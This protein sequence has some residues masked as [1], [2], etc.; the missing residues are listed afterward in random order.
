[1]VYV[2]SPQ[3]EIH[4]ILGIALTLMLVLSLGMVFT[5]APA[6]ADPDEWSTYDLPEE[7]ADGDYFYDSTI[8][9]GPGPI[10]RGIDGTFWVY[11]E[12]DG[13]DELLRSIDTEGRGWEATEYSADVGGGA[14]VAIAPSSI[15]ADVV[16]VADATKVYKTEDGGDSFATVVESGLDLADGEEISCLSV[17]YLAD[18]SPFVFIGTTGS[19]GHV[20]YLDE[21]AFGA[22]WIDLELGGYAVYGL[23]V[24]PDFDHDTLVAALAGLN[25]A[26]GGGGTGTA[27]GWSTIR[28][29]SGT[30]SALLDLV[31][32]H[33]YVDFIPDRG[34]TLGDLDSLTNAWGFW[35]YQEAS[36]GWG[37]QLELKFAPDPADFGTDFIDITVMAAQ[38]LDLVEGSWTGVTLADDL[39]S[40]VWWGG[41]VAE[42][43]EFHEGGKTLQEAIDA[44]LL[45]GV[46][47]ASW[48]LARVRV[49]LWEPSPPRKCY[50]DDITIDGTTYD[51]EQDVGLGFVATNDGSVGVWDYLPLEDVITN[52]SDPAFVEDFDIDDAFEFFVGVCAYD[53]TGGV[54]RVYDETNVEKVGDVDKAIISLDLAGN[55]GD[56]YL[57]AGAQG[58]ADVWYSDDDGVSWL[59]ASDEG[60]Q[61]SGATNTY[62]IADADIANNGIGWAATGVA[63]GAVSMT[64]DGGAV[65]LG[66]SLIDTTIDSIEGLAMS[67]DFASPGLMFV[68]TDSGTTDSVFRYDGT[69]WERVYESTQYNQAIDLIAVSPDINTD[70][71]VFLGDTVSNAIQSTRATL[72]PG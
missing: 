36:E 12:F 69:N 9:A 15:D 26:F 44:V 42:G 67:P 33:T 39:T 66:I 1:V 11:V 49:E 22:A 68:L 31:D 60:I 50:I 63:E 20:Y 47:D 71:T 24:S 25:F 41:G 27:T 52:G 58:A 43:V 72:I 59:K 21:E 38:G 46:V 40:V 70:N 45:S 37:P 35:Y 54:Y 62:V 5:A 17:G 28:A 19:P 61:P 18:D 56:T 13:A 29:K 14:I 32:A 48:E 55:Q 57:L 34:T 6:A 2:N 3:G 10:A 53:G 64:T 51:L 4:K 30:T 65:W 7:G 16:Y 8:T 23:G